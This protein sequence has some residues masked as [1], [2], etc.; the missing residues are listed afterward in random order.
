VNNTIDYFVIFDVDSQFFCLL[1]SSLR[2]LLKLTPIFFVC[3]GGIF[4][5]PQSFR[6][7]VIYHALKLLLFGLLKLLSIRPV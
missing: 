3:H 2:E 5:F 1:C 7:S 6:N 4:F